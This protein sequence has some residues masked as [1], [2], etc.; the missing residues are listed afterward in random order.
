MCSSDD[1]GSGNDDDDDDDE[2]YED[3]D[4]DNYEDEEE[5][6]EAVESPSSTNNNSVKQIDQ[7]QVN[8]ATPKTPLS[9]TETI[10]DLSS[11]IANF[12]VCSPFDFNASNTNNV[13]RHNSISR[14]IESTVFFF[15]LLSHVFD[16]TSEP[17]H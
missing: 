17:I 13:R 8:C 16:L 7:A 15:L 3:D 14:D 6:E 11:M 12:N 5:E 9:Q 4:D 2:N 1:E 10:T